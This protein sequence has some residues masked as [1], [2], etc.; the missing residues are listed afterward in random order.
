MI[1][2]LLDIEQQMRVY[3]V[4]QMSAREDL[5]SS[6]MNQSKPPKPEQSQ[7][8]R[9]PSLD[10]THPNTY[11]PSP[12]SFPAN[13]N[14]KIRGI[15]ENDRKSKDVYLEFSH[16]AINEPIFHQKNDVNPGKRDEHSNMNKQQTQIK[17][18]DTFDK[19]F[20]K[21]IKLTQENGGVENPKIITQDN[22]NVIESN[23]LP[24]VSR[25]E[26]KISVDFD[27][28]FGKPNTQQKDNPKETDEK[29]KNNPFHIH[30][31]WF[32]SNEG[33]KLSIAKSQ[34]WDN[35]FNLQDLKFDDETWKSKFLDNPG[36]KKEE[37]AST[38]DQTLTNKDITSSQLKKFIFY[39][40]SKSNYRSLN[41]IL[42]CC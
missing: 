40:I 17:I 34:S 5:P 6:G 25:E 23:R 31:D 2:H 4:S 36:S 20:Q 1:N 30:D 13:N 24:G 12:I 11:L 35:V 15:I 26:S 33:N 19:L 3:E 29:N 22:K 42:R 18:D 21:T 28:L 41:K 9:R 10:L 27:N 16:Q 7:I 39:E 38:S 8:K 37:M 32:I 14:S